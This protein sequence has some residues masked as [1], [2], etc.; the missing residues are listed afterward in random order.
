MKLRMYL[1]G[2]GLG[3]IVAALVL[4]FGVETNNRTMSDAQIRARAL[5][6]GMVDESTTLK[7]S[8]E[9]AVADTTET[10]TPTMKPTS[11][12]TEIPTETPTETPK[13]TPT[14]T[15]KPTPTE[16]P[17]PTPT[18]TPKP[19]PTETPKPTPT[20]TPTPTPTEA[21][22]KVFTEK[23]YKLTIV[24]G[25]SS[26]KVAKILEDAGIVD[27]AVSFDKYLCENHYDHRISTG[28]YVIPAGADY[29]TIAKIITN[30]K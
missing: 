26:D 7:A 2:L 15:P 3:F 19:T 30:S 29:G 13:P 1:R 17:T 12:P 20:E 25:Y 8:E 6:L 22:K 28:T 10:L 18:E 14:E 27:N 23:S 5:E 4:S 16:T 21:P 11:T 9:K 24:G